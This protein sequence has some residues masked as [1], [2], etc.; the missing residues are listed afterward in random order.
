MVVG[1]TGLVGRAIVSELK[2]SGIQV[3][4]V[5]RKVCDLT[6]FEDTN[7]LIRTFK[8]D[9]VIDAAAKVGGIVSNSKLPVEYLEINSLIQINLFRACHYNSIQKLVFLSSSCVY[10]KLAPQ[11]IKESSLMTG[12]LEETNSAYA[13]AKISGMRLVQAYREEFGYKWITVMPT[14]LFGYHDNFSLNNSHLLPA[15][16]RKF[17][18]AKLNQLNE[19]TLWGT[20][21]PRREMMH[22]NNF[23]KALKFVIEKYDDFSP[24]NIGTGIDHSIA[25]IAETVKRVV[26]YDCEIKWD[27]EKPDGTPRKILDITKL[28]KIGFKEKFNLENDISLT[29]DWFIKNYLNSPENLRL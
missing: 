8:P 6:N 4:E 3:I 7:K 19:V 10:P 12:E 22:A 14:N 27:T 25:E 11:P 29:N 5:S 28:Q 15:L 18:E 26:G 16:I 13:I 2:N 20:G 1:A 24:I 23:A 9:I 17:N 21:K